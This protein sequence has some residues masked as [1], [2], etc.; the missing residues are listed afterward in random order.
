MFQWK[1]KPILCASAI[2]LLSLSAVV[3]D[4]MATTTP[5]PPASLPNHLKVPPILDADA[6]KEVDPCNNFYQFA[7]GKWLD[8]TVIP[9]EKES[10]SHQAT[11]LLDQTDLTLNKILLQ[12]SKSKVQKAASK[13]L[14]D[15]YQSCMNF[16]KTTQSAKQLLS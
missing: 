11:A 10:L 12:L 13:Q 3:A 14:V 4:A 8:S 15:L 1:I 16:A 5:P 2:A 9:P 6:L 7:C